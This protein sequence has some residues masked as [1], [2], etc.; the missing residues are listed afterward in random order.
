MV[1]ARRSPSKCSATDARLVPAEEQLWSKAFVQDRDRFDGA[2]VIH[3]ILR[4][5]AKI[6]WDS[7]PRFAGG[8]ERV[9]LAHLILFGYAYPSERAA[10][11]RRK[12]SIDCWI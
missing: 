7:S 2:D 3:L 12:Y 8:H 4:A 10:A 11:C 6:D 5:A 9:L 1:R